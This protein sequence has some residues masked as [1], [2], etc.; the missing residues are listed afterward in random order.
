MIAGIGVDIVEVSRFQSML[1]RYGNRVAEKL[2][3]QSELAQFKQSKQ[4]ASFLSKRFA[5]KEAAVKA[6]GCGFGQGIWYQ[7]IEVINLPSGQPLLKFHGQAAARMS[8]KHILSSFVSLSDE[9]N[10]VV[11]MVLLEK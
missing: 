1:D 7:T 9:K 6:L 8:R 10:A 11:A 5:A 4:Q 2:L 3:S